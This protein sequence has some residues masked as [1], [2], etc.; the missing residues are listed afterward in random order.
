MQLFEPES[1]PLSSTGDVDMYKWIPVAQ[2]LK[3]M[4]IAAEI[5]PSWLA[6]YIR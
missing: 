2:A 6:G 3:N 1:I 4:N 5:S